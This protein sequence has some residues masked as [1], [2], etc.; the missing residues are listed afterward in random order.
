MV[1]RSLNHPMREGEPSPRE[2]ETGP[3]HLP[4][5]SALAGGSGISLSLLEALQGIRRGADRL[6]ETQ[7]VSAAT[8]DHWEMA[9]GTYEYLRM[10]APAPVLLTQMLLDFADLQQILGSR[11]PLDFQRRL[12]R[13]MAQLAGMIGITL[14]DNS[15]HRT[16]TQAWFHTARLAADETGDRILRAWVAVAESLSY[17]WYGRPAERAVQLAQTAQALAGRPATD[18]RA[19]AHSLEARGQALLGYRREALTAIRSAETVYEHLPPD[20]VQ[21]GGFGFH[22]HLMHYCQENALTLASE[23][24]AA[25]AQQDEAFRV[26][27]AVPAHRVLVALDR[28]NCLVRAGDPDEGCR[29]ASQSLTELPAGPWPGIVVF[30]AKEVATAATERDG[31]LERARELRET[32]RAAKAPRP[33]A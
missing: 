7:S 11:Q 1:T 10:T 29:I 19:W 3:R 2:E 24:K 20:A 8:V 21:P 23:L 22:A 32:L 13:V 9:A 15:D 31:H 6:L 30:R 17:L 18:V 16:E 25:L 27:P 14:V 33:S 5:P 4:G 28:A 26:S 12:Y